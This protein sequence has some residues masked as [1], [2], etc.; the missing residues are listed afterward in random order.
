ME[1][2]SRARTQSTRRAFFRRL[3]TAAVV[4]A[5]AGRSTAAREAAA[6]A[7]VPSTG[8]P[9]APAGSDRIAAAYRIRLEAAEQCRRLPGSPQVPNGD[10]DD[11]AAYQGAYSKGLPHDDLGHVLPQS[12]AALRAALQSGDPATFERLAIGGALKQTNPQA[13]YAFSLEGGDSQQFGVPPA[14]S[15]R[16]PELAAEMVELYWHAVTRD[17]PFADFETDPLVAQAA[18]ELSALEDFTGPRERGRVTPRTL[19]RGAT[20]GDLTGPYLSQ[21]LILDVPY[22][23]I[24]LEQKIQAAAAGMDFLT[25]Y[26]EWLQVQNGAAPNARI[27]EDPAPRHLRHQ[28]DLGEYV[29]VDFTYQAFLNAALILLARREQRD[30]ADPYRLSRTQVGFVSFGSAHVLDLVARVATAALK[31]CW[32]QKWLVHRRLRPEEL[33][34]RVHNERRRAAQY[35]LHPSLLHARAVDLVASRH[36]SALLPQAYPE[37]APT[38]P[39]YPSGHAVVAGACATALKALFNE[40]RIFWEAKEPARDGLALRAYA[41]PPLTIGGELDKLA[42]NVAIGRNA[43]G[44]HYRSDATAGLVLGE[45][46]ALSVLR[47]QRACFT[48]PCDGLT[49]T[50]FDGSLLT[51]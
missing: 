2:N 20:R 26:A 38:H 11:G 27:V 43:A 46:V 32:Y 28:R 17:V 34:G 5:A 16:S 21:F 22:G 51:I 4:T 23:A 30:L 15:L 47:D 50:G 18:E 41:G 6:P 24:D 10:E 3:S 13:A 36:G 1:P 29:R 14:P 25:G 35:G 37:G 31:A 12:Y 45:A 42:S 48:E 19:F 9:E 33:G 40:G 49:V 39:S 44:V 8:G 7:G